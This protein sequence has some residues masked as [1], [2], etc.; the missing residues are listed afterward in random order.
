MLIRTLKDLQEGATLLAHLGIFMLVQVCDSY[1][2]AFTRKC[3]GNCPADAAVCSS[4]Q[5]HLGI[6]FGPVTPFSSIQDLE[7]T[8]LCPYGVPTNK[9]QTRDHLSN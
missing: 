4:D 2:C 9:A 3:Q 5:S 6:V 7:E 1:V 8:L